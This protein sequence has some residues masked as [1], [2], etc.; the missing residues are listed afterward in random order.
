MHHLPKV[1]I[2]RSKRDEEQE[3]RVSMNSQGERISATS[4]LLFASGRL[5]YANTYV[6]ALAYLVA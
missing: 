1:M 2:A 6:P 4:F 3:R 5:V